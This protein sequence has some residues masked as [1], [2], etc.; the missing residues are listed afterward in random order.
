MADSVTRT[1]LQR[2]D[3][4]NQEKPTRP[5]GLAPP[6]EPAPTRPSPAPPTAAPLVAG[7]DVQ[8]ALAT[9]AQAPRRPYYD[10]AADQA[11]QAA[12]YRSIP[13][14]LTPTQR[15]QALSGLVRA[16]HTTTPRYRPMVELYPWVDLH[17]DLALHTIYADTVLDPAQLIVEDFAAEAQRVAR[18]AAGPET[19]DDLEAELA[20]NCEH[21][22]PQSWFAKAE[23]MRGDL[24]HLFACEVRCNSFRGN[25]PYFDFADY[26]HHDVIRDACGRGEPDRF[27][28][29]AGKGPVARAS[30][31]FLLRYPGVVDPRELPPGRLGVLLGWHEQFPVGEY[32]RHRNAA[33]FARQGNR[34]PLI[35]HPEWASGTDFTVSLT[36]DATDRDAT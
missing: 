2:S 16:T 31:Y 1:L 21:V 27:E 8:A 19:V 9:L 10:P 24:H 29:Q 22:V 23:P 15:A 20:Y 33:V 12:Y 25:T 28:P 18:L 11:D 4:V 13:A 32:E 30:L 26:P 5:H 14:D 34:N 36:D 35:D 6:G 17:P 3:T 7:A